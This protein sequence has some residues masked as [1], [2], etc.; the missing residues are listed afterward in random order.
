MPRL[1]AKQDLADFA[2]VIIAAN[3]LVTYQDNLYVAKNFEDGGPLPP[4]DK[5]VWMQLEKDELMEW[6]QSMDLLFYNPQEYYNWTFMIRQMAER[7]RQ[8]EPY[9]VIRHGDGL[10]YMTDAGLVAIETPSFAPNYINHRIIEE[11]S[12]EYKNVRT[13]FATIT[14]WLGDEDQAHS[15]LYHLATA[16]QPGWTPVKYLLLLG[17]GR[18]GK[19]TLL[20]ML[21]KLLGERNLS[22]VLRQ[23]IA[24]RKATV[25]SVAGKL[26]NIVFDGP[27]SYVAESGPEKTLTAG[28]PLHIELKYDNEPRR[29]QSNC[30][31]VEAL[32]KEP[33]NR[34]KSVALQSRLVRFYFPNYYELDLQFGALMTSDTMID[35]FLTLLWEH[36]VKEDEVAEKL[37]P[38]N[39]SVDLQ[40]ASELTGS[41]ILAFIEWQVRRNEEFLTELRSGK[42]NAD[43]FVDSLQP[44]LG[45]QGYGDRSS[46]SIW[47]QMGDHFVIERGVSRVNGRP[48]TVKQIKSILPRTE[49]ALQMMEGGTSDD[50]AVVRDE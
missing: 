24:A 45:D 15:L 10:A 26:A 20:A 37:R 27:A 25:A 2:S 32:Q 1:Q 33:K 18:N 47:E 35:A 21:A 12:D 38:T 17:S 6:A 19:G 42:F 5:T 9:V 16:L 4:P 50:E 14:E 39:S 29:V 49:R 31:W 30:L 28:E 48:K 13:L 41:P 44:W 8:A 7:R 11:G 34:D 36:W 46:A 23:D 22:G 43:A 40:T 3:R